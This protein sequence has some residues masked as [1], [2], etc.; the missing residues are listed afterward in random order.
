M[1]V[2]LTT[3]TLGIEGEANIGAAGFV[4]TAGATVDIDPGATFDLQGDFTMTRNADAPVER[5]LNAGTLKKTA[6]AGTT[7]IDPELTNTGVVEARSGTLFATTLTNYSPATDT[8]TG[9]TYFASST[10]AFTDADIVVNAANF[11]LDT[12]G[13]VTNGSQSAF[14]N[15]AT[16][17][18]GGDLRLINSHVLTTSSAF[19]NAGDLHVEGATRF[20]ATGIL[21]NSG[22]LEGTGVVEGDV[23]NG[24]LVQ[25]GLSPGT[26]HI[27]GPFVSQPAGSL[28]VEIAG[29]TP[30]SQHDQL[31]A[32][33]PITLD[34]TLTIETDP[35]FTPV[36]GDSF[37]IMTGS[38]VTGTFDDLVG[39]ELGG[40]LRYVVSTTPTAVVLNVVSRALVIADDSVE[41]GETAS[42][43]VTLTPADPD[44]PVTVDFFTSEASATDP[45]DYDGQ[46]GTLTF[47][48][49]ETTKTISVP[50]VD[51]ALDESDELFAVNLEEP[52]GATLADSS[53]SGQIADDDEPGPVVEADLNIFN[54]DSPDPVATGGELTYSLFVQNNGPSDAQNVVLLDTL[55]AGVTIV[56]ATPSAGGVCDTTSN[57]ISCTFPTVI[58]FGGAQ[59]EIVVTA[60]SVP[61]QI[62]NTASISSSVPD[63]N[64]TDNQAE[65]TTT[66]ASNADLEVTK[67]AP[68]TATIGQPL[69][70]TI[71]VE[72]LGPDNATVANIEDSLPNGVELISTDPAACDTPP[73]QVLCELGPIAVGATKTVTIVVR[74]LAGG[75]IANTVQVS[76]SADPDEGNNFDFADTQVAL[77]NDLKITKT[78]APT[79][80]Y[81]GSPIVYTLT[82]ENLGTLSATGVTVEDT[83]PA[84][85]TF[86]SAPGCSEAAGVVTCPL[87]SLAPGASASAT[88]TVNPTSTGPKL[89]VAEVTGNEADQ[90]S[91][92]NSVQHTAYVREPAPDI[93]R[94]MITNEDWLTG[95]SFLT[96]PPL[97]F[98]NAVGTTPLTTFPLHGPNYAIM[99]SG[100]AEL[101]DDPNNSGGSG[102][103]DGGGNIRGDTDFDVSVLK[104][105]LD[106]PAGLNCLS[107][108]FR[109][110]SDEFPEFVGQRY[111][112][113]LILELNQTTWDTAGSIITAPHNFAFDPT[114]NVIS[115]NAAGATSMTAAHATGTTYDGATPLLSASTIVSPGPNSLYVSVFDQG[116][117]ILD[118]AAFLD[119]LNLAAVEPTACVS[120]ATA[121]STVKT[122][123]APT[124]PAGAV[125]GYTITIPNITGGEITVQ[126]VTDDLPAGFTYRPGTTTGVTT[127]DP[128]IDGQT[129]TWTGPFTVPAGQTLTL[130]FDVN[131]STTPGEYLNNA[132][133]TA[134]VPVTP[135]GPTAQIT[136][137]AA[138]TR[139]RWSMQGR[140]GPWTRAHP[141]SRPARSSTRTR[142]PGPAP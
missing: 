77:E 74:P 64:P 41:E 82:V 57:P 28:A 137:E 88:L 23:R 106:V 98:P 54:F 58:A 91:F 121:L 4:L 52:A 44:N 50:T 120:G 69:T 139:H 109:F 76:G 24:G 127:A 111:N 130:G 25:P 67:T 71:V 13:S 141:S 134:S 48:P 95:A 131:V 7:R 124:S 128:T 83:L 117:Q 101:A 39:D 125:N 97:N 92:N 15:L 68:A 119:A 73:G 21:T 19:T 5:I 59:V 100:Q 42:F 84:G 87:G 49:N 30:G 66:V 40:G 33:G 102:A 129:L 47:A 1:T 85:V 108:N 14:R 114:G 18:V 56:E 2:T 94:A 26:L 60:P 34:G 20:E 53:A 46:S 8:I 61:G 79:R 112:D 81:L 72:N 116:D 122:A 113:A 10:F 105:D 90:D 32:T 110:L 135:T 9:G 99:T 37:V 136:V 115:I 62:T 133:A 22:L 31:V 12:T 3:R 38:S 70:Y 55:P 45:E 51:D 89:N 142:T 138:P 96:D 107:V 132:G 86:V 140:T 126:S 103:N 118:S 11:I 80:N 17:A 36:E 65:T 123:D 104:V 6:G 63:P 27:E 35:A 16:N 29:Q 93:A 75:L 43:D 78:A